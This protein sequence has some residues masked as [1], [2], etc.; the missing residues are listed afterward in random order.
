MTDSFLPLKR[1][2]FIF[3]AS[4]KIYYCGSGHEKS[5]NG[6]FCAYFSNFQRIFQRK[7][8]KNAEAENSFL[9]RVTIILK[10][11]VLTNNPELKKKKKKSVSGVLLGQIFYVYISYKWILNTNEV[12]ICT[13]WTWSKKSTYVWKWTE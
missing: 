8:E 13:E 12:S 4:S 3:K 11:F 9:Q 10:H 1:K 5:E 2:Y 6:V 7:K